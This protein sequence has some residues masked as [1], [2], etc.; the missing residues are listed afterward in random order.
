MAMGLYLCM[1]E[2]FF[3]PLSSCPVASQYSSKVLLL[4][5]IKSISGK[6]IYVSVICFVAIRC[7]DSVHSS[8]ALEIL[9][10][11]LKMC[12]GSEDECKPL[13]LGKVVSYN[14]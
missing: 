11:E 13:I 10:E 3:F 2:L 9:A 4:K 7:H 5:V 8:K 6:L 1:S 12:T 14:T